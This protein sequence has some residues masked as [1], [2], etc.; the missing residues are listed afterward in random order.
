MFTSLP[1]NHEPMVTPAPS[2]GLGGAPML[3]VLL[4]AFVAIAMYK[5][6]QRN[7]EEELEKKALRKLLAKSGMELIETEPLT[8]PTQ[9]ETVEPVLPPKLA[10]PVQPVSPAPVMEAVLPPPAP[11]D[12]ADQPHDDEPVVH[13][14]VNRS[15]VFIQDAHDSALQ[16][17]LE[18]PHQSEEEWEEQDRRRELMSQEITPEMEAEFEAMDANRR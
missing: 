1:V 14:P 2:N 9:P 18:V 3:F 16:E 15:R 4:L 12:E 8:P 17:G 10:E 5:L 13:E 6:G 7:K 11:Q